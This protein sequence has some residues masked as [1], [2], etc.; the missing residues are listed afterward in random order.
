MAQ[1]GNIENLIAARELLT[2]SLEKSKH[3]ASAIDKTGRKL[4]EINQRL[5]SLEAAIKTLAS[6]CSLSEIGRHIDPTVGP[7][8]AVL[9]VFDAVHMLEESLS[10]DPCSNLFRYLSIV[11]QLEEALKFLTDNCGLVIRWLE[12]AVRFLE[13]N[14]VV[15]DDRYLLN[16]NKCLRILEELRVT[17]EHSLL[18]GGCLCAAYGKLESEF[19]RILMENSFPLPMASS[20]VS[21]GEQACIA[22]LPFPVPVIQKLQAIIEKL[23]T[24]NRLEKCISMYVEVRSLNARATLQAL[25]LDYREIS[26][27]E[28]DSVQ[29]VEGYIDQW[30]KH[31]EFA[32]KHVF[33][34]EYKLC[35]NV[36]EKVGS[37]VWMGCFAK[38]TVQSGLHDFIKFGNTITKG[39]KDAIKLL[40][41]LDIFAALNKLRLDFNRLFGGKACV[42]IQTRTRDLIKKVVNGASEIFWELS[43]QV[44]LQRQSAP[45]SD[46]SV[47]RLLSFVTD[48]CNLLLHDNYRPILAQVLEIHRSWDHA[49]FEEE[50]L[51]HEVHDIIKAIELNLETWAKTYEDTTLS[52]LFLMNNHWYLYKNLKG[53]KLGDLMGD[54]WLQGHEQYMEY[55]ATLYLRESWGKLPAMLSE[56]GLI[57]FPGGRAIDHDLVK[58]RLEVF[59]DAFDGMYK[60]QC[61]WAVSD[62]S[63]RGKACQLVVQIIV[64]AYQKFLQTYMPWVQ[65]EAS[66]SR[67]TKYSA[68]RLKNMVCSLF[69]PKLGMYGSNT[70]TNMM[71]NINN[72][73]I[74]QLSS[75]PAAA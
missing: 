74:N 14:A 1:L 49:K 36:F 28:F 39:K 50:L 29:S 4:E 37:D 25:D 16:L 5:P 13:G 35:E 10:A 15:D 32:V 2:S 12:D 23:T 8:A 52:Y 17:E 61:S 68:E 62:K 60:K 53:T 24:S 34:L 67:N 48:Y 70:C 75:T 41:L 57:L 65:Q 71:G 63:L 58:K 72:A 43:V 31:L 46:G 22:S 40:K 33:E 45:P 56:E 73:A 27:S 54:S 11:K 9:N 47:P 64:P 19:R 26:L 30:C 21:V 7:A 20:S 55:Y 6:K 66:P 59:M 51:S 38:V 18:S 42:E 3:L 69:Q 44:E